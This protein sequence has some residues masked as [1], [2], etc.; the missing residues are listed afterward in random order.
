ML[1]Q[2]V[3]ISELRTVI[4]VIECSLEVTHLAEDIAEPDM[5]V[6]R[7]TQRR[8]TLA[9]AERQAVGVHAPASRSRP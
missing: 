9:H 4:Q 2:T 5:H 8:C 6:R 3:E 1:G 7:A